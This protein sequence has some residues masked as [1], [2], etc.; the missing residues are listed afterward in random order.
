MAKM[1]D[2]EL[3][4]AVNELL[5]SMPD[6]EHIHE[7][8]PENMVWFG[9]YLAV[10]KA[11]D[12]PVHL[13]NKKNV[14]YAQN[15]I[16]GVRKAGYREIM[17]SLHQAQHDLTLKT[18]G[19]TSVSVEGGAVFDYFNEIRGIIELAQ[20]DILFVD[21][22]LDAAF[23]PRY[24]PHARGGVSVR[25]L[26]EHK[27]TTLYPSVEEYTKQSGASVSIRKTQGIHDRYVFI[28]R[29][30]CY[31]SGASFKDGAK[32]AQTTVTQIVDAF[33]AIHRTYEGLWEAG[34]IVE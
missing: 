34:E 26:T 24:L 31:Q 2:D 22:Y 33:D 23:V 13:E 12:L 7:Q 5:R 18:T 27:I 16:E 19:P 8:I 9:R 21:P 17:I 28:D 11:W 15:D 1:A 4:Q 3:L 25:L 32:K 6:K 10:T 14:N 30:A 29:T 20:E